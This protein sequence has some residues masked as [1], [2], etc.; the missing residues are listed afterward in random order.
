MRRGRLRNS[1]H[2]DMAQ[3]IKILPVF[4]GGDVDEGYGKV[5]LH[6]FSDPR[7]LG[8]RQALLRD[9]LGARTQA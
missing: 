6:P 4:I 8:L 9:V 5:A 1:I 3:K 7:E 2:A